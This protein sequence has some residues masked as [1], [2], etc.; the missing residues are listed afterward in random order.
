MES[1]NHKVYFKEIS[2]FL[3]SIILCIRTRYKCNKP[4]TE[5]QCILCIWNSGLLGKSASTNSEYQAF[6]SDSLNKPQEERPVVNE[7]VIGKVYTLLPLV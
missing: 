4:I 1:A 7:N 5:M 3:V 6:F 2:V